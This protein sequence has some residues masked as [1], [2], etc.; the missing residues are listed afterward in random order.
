MLFQ[1]LL[2]TSNL[3]L[4]TTTFESARFLAHKQVGHA[5]LLLKMIQTHTSTKVAL[6]KAQTKRSICLQADHD[7]KI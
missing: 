6:T 4:P 3:S 5:S 2:R 7:G 1:M